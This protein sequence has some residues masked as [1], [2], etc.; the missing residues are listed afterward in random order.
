MRCYLKR[1]NAIQGVIFIR[2]ASRPELLR[3]AALL[4]NKHAHEFDGY[5]VW[6]AD[7]WLYSFPVSATQHDAQNDRHKR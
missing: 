3:E 4:F 7:Q 6:H 2:A 1:G 5:E